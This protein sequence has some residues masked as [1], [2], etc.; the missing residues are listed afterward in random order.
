M[1]DRSRRRSLS[2][3]SN[4]KLFAA[5]VLAIL[6]MRYQSLRPQPD[7]RL[8]V[9]LLGRLD[10]TA[11]PGSSAPAEGMGP[12]RHRAIIAGMQS[13]SSSQ[14]C[15]LVHIV[16]VEERERI[17]PRVATQEVPVVPWP[18]H[19]SS[20]SAWSSNDGHAAS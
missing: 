17:L 4:Q 10:H 15:Q 20:S 13:L 18:N 11:S 3:F 5:I 7:S 12:A 16:D 19:T 9:P 1:S 2:V 14:N 8:L 6:T